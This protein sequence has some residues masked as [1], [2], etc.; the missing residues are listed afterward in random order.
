MPERM[1]SADEVAKHNS[2]ES[3]HVIVHGQIYDVTEFLPDHPG[4]FDRLGEGQ[5]REREPLSYSYSQRL[6][7]GGSAIIL[8]Y[9]G[10]DAT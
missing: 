6:L 2:K 5:E 8:K 1:I 3:C 7:V 4:E 9:A 10:K